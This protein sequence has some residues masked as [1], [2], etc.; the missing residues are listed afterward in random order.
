[1]AKSEKGKGATKVKS[2]EQ[3]NAERREAKAKRRPKGE[4]VPSYGNFS[5][6]A[7]EQDR[8]HRARREEDD[9]RE[10]EL[11]RQAREDE[12]NARVMPKVDDY[13]KQLTANGYLFLIRDE[14]SRQDDADILEEQDF[15]RVVY[16]LRQR[17]QGTSYRWKSEDYLW[18]GHKYQCHRFTIIKEMRG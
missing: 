4:S 7:V 6:R 5:F 8:E 2:A 16:A 18:N 10:R 1:M 11:A 14:E 17:V 15:G 9:Q 3:H 13:Y 12:I